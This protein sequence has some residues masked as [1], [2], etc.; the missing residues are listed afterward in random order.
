M[1]ENPGAFNR[2]LSEAIAGFM[3]SALPQEREP[4]YLRH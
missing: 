4:E 1:L 2:L 3:A